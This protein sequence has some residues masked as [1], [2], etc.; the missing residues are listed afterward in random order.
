[1]I[2]LTKLSRSQISE[3]ILKLDRW[4]LNRGRLHKEYE[5]DDFPSAISFITRIAPLAEKLDHHP[6]IFNSYNKVVIELHTHEVKGLTE[7]DFELA[8]MIDSARAG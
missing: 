5:F 2:A 8:S 4:R 3:R 1:M 6:D 7:K